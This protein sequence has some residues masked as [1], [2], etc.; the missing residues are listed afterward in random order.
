MN[1]FELK[2]LLA[3]NGNLPSLV[4]MIPAEDITHP[5]L[6]RLWVEMA[7]KDAEMRSITR[8]FYDTLS[9]L[10]GDEDA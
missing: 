10:M 6:R 2:K 5:E 4:S 1:A 3:W 9:K 7:A 8:K